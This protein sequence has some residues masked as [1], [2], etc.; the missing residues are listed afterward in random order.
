M[1]QS[2]GVN[3]GAVEVTNPLEAWLSIEPAPESGCECVDRTANAV[4]QSVST[5]PRGGAVCR[6]FLDAGKNKETTYVR[7]EPVGTCPRAVL[8]SCDCIPRLEKIGD[9]R[10]L[11]SAT[12]PD[13]SC[14]ET[15]IDRLRE[16]DAEVSV[17]RLRYHD[18]TGTS[19]PLLTDKQR[20]AFETA[21]DA[22]YFDRPR[23]ATLEDLADELGISPSAVSHRLCSARRRIAKH[24]TETVAVEAD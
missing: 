18:Y 3:R 12:M 1:T 24:Y 16:T 19:V 9:G 11:Y 6:L 7:S 14:L 2:E 22:G 13:R 5:D 21:V 17:V 15:T 23:N 20:E 4:R 8:A 10:M